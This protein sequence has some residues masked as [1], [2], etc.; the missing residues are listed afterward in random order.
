M[1]VT[2]ISTAELKPC[3]LCGQHKHLRYF[4][5][6]NSISYWVIK[7]DLCRLE[8]HDM[9]ADNAKVKWNKRP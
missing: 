4:E 7:C 1:A 3:P 9:Q 6:G 8:L 2:A 5:R